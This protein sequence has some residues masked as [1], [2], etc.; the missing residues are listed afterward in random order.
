MQVVE[1]GGFSFQP[2]LGYDVEI[3]DNIIG[4]FHPAGT[5]LIFIMGVTSNQSDQP[6]EAILDEFLSEFAERGDGEFQ[7]EISHTVTIDSFEGLAF[8]LTGTLFDSP[9]RG[10]ALIVVPSPNQFLFGL[11]IANTEVDRTRWE[12]EGDT[13]FSALLNSIKFLTIHDPGSCPVSADET[14]GYTQEN[15]I[16]VGGGALGG[17]ARERAYLDNLR[18]P[19]G[20]ELTYERLGA[21]PF[22]DTILDIFEVRGLV[23]PVIL[24]LDEYSYTEPQAP[25]GFTC[26]AAFPLAPP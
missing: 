25:A 18:G 7:K 19:H 4:V 6:P 1:E 2:P 5:I 8:D 22:G 20:E 16:K 12:N 9:L 21:F 10:Q 13:V 14:Y 17:P 24:Y 26:V 15:P 3:E 11:G 23:T